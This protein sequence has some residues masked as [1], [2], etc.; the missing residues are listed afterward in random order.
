MFIDNLTNIQSATVGGV[1]IGYQYDA[2]NRLTNVLDYGLSGPKNTA[3]TYNAVG[4]LQTLHYPNGV[5]NFYQ[6]DRL[7]RLTNLVWKL[8]TTTLG[9]FYYQVGTTGNRTNAVESVNSSNRTN[10]WAYDPLYRLTNE[11]AIAS[12]ANGV[13]AYQYDPVGNRSN[14]TSSITGL[15]NQTLAFTTNDWL[16]T[17][18]YDSNGNTTNSASVAYQYDYA[19]R[20]TNAGNGSVI[21]TYGADDNRLSKTVGGV[22]MLYL[23]AVE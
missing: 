9:S 21:V 13:L 19:N 20:L 17:D 18:G 2:L 12:S 1:S 8:N 23:V 11:T 5:T 22:T 4:D 3:Y 15:A 16:T 14:R 10:K 7:N 6:Y